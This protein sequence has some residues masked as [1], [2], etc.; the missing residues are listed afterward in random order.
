[1][2]ILISAGEASGDRY[3]SELKRALE[4]HFPGAEWFGCAGPKLRAAGVEPVIRSES[5]AVVGLVEVL[6]HIPR[7]YGEFRTLTH[8]S[9]A[10]KPDFAILADA[11]DFHLR[12]AK[13]LHAQGV[14]VFYYVAPQLWAWRQGRAK[15]LRRTLSQ[16]YCIFPFEVDF[17]T[18]R[19]VPTEYIGH[20]LAHQIAADQ[21]RAT[22]AQAHG[23][24][25]DQPIIAVLPGS[26]Q[27]EAAR[28]L[29]PLAEAIERLAA[30]DP[31][32]QFVL[33]A[34]ST[35][36]RQFFR[37]RLGGKR[38]HIIDGNARNALAHAELALVAS[39]TATVEAALLGT[40]MVV[41]YRVTETTWRLGKLLV[42]VPHFSMVNLLAGQSLV[43]ELIQHD[44]TGE[45][46]AAAAEELLQD[47]G[48]RR[49][50]LEGLKSI[51]ETLR[52]S[53]PPAEHAARHIAQHPAIQRN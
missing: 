26:R 13:K 50:I 39:G 52:T 10:R 25:A 1:M 18:E 23:V 46:V 49:R 12:L 21:D 51:Q 20:P 11:P 14:P 38:V 44:F 41:V 40:P 37:Q 6:R 17:F 8:A 45:R 9:R 7:I 29:P 4:P 42:D 19:G 3:A 15:I 22:F 33:P 24:T 34:S 16:L 32:R 53:E 43:P 47:S 30:A 2:R 36:G 31:K 28:N 35:T 48:E 5:L 27:G